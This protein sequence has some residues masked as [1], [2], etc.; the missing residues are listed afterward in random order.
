M[1]SDFSFLNDQ[2]PN[3]FAISELSEKLIYIDPSSSLSKSRLFSEKLSILVW[4]FEEMGEFIGSQNNRIYRLAN[5]NVAP[6]IIASILHTVRKS[7]NK[8]SHD[9]TGSFEEA[10][11]IL[12]KCFQLAKWFYETY[13]QDYLEV[14]S[15]GFPEKENTA[16]DSLSE[17]L[18]RLSK[19]VTDYKNKIAELNKNKEEVS[20]RKQRSDTRARNLDLSEEDTRLTLIDPKLKEAGWEC[21]TLIFNYKKNKTLPEK[22]KNMAIAEW[23][24]E[25]KWADY[26][27]FV[28]TTLYGIVEAKKFAN[29]ISTDL[30]QSNVYAKRIHS[31]DDFETLGEWQD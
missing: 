22:N 27:L 18:E 29:D 28:G 5:A 3:L 16:S 26:A 10:H 31:T 19:E 1:N 14:S 12:K 25:V 6:D 9:G 15:Y 13:E 2:Y 21:D 4:D 17:E 24:C 11:F 7:G 8:A 20:A 23:P 30:R